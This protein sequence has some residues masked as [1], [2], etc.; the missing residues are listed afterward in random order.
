MPIINT[1]STDTATGKV[2]EIYGQ[3]TQAFGC[4]PNAL[5]MHSASPAILEQQWQSIGYYMQH[6]ALSFP[7]QAMVRML[8]SERNHCEYCVGFNASMLINRAALTVEQVAV[9]KRDP[10]QAP[11]PEKDK[12]M[13][14]FVLKAVTEPLKVT[15]AEVAALRKQGWSD[16][17]I[18]DAV[19]LGARNV[20]ADIVFNT[21]KIEQ[22]F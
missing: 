2:R 19:M 1:V 8:V 22:D 12:A 9:T 13:L 11:L 4:V 16:S 7:L 14:L 18:L 17:D 20:A 6:P 5:Q 10:S 15:A 21:F 3:A